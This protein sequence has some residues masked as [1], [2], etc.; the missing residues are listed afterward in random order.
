MV[1]IADVFSMSAVPA[2]L[3]V[4]V[5][6]RSS[7]G[8]EILVFVSL[9]V[10]IDNDVCFH[11]PACGLHGSAKYYSSRKSPITIGSC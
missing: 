2:S 7:K 5:P 3:T 11:S 1:P 8:L 4:I 10:K 6:R 9:K